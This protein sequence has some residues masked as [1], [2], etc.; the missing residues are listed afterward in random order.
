GREVL[1][2]GTMFSND[3]GP[4]LHVHGVYGH[5]RDVLMGCLREYAETYLIM[6]VILLEVVGSGAFKK[7]DEN[8]LMMLDFIK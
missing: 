4:V 2:I 1:G 3:G 7:I 6:E 5:D 8:G